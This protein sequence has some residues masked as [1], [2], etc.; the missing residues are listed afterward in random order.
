MIG[1]YNEDN[2]KKLKTFKVDLKPITL[3]K[4]TKDLLKELSNKDDVVSRCKAFILA[5]RI[6]SKE[7]KDYADLFSDLDGLQEYINKFEY[8][9]FGKSR[10]LWLI[11]TMIRPYEYDMGIL[12]QRTISISKDDEDW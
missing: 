7:N 10:F 4:E 9:I 3:D 12:V 5:R 6:I 8:A 11:N 1:Y 2:L